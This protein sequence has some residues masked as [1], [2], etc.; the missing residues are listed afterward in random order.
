MSYLY[1][2]NFGYGELG[3]ALGTGIYTMTM[4]VGHNFP[5]DPSKLF[6][7]LIWD[8]TTYPEPADDP[9]KEIVTAYYS[10]TANVYVITRGDEGTTESSH[11]S[12]DACAM[13]ITAALMT[14]LENSGFPDY[15][16]G[17]ILL[18]SSDAP[19]TLINNPTVLTKAK[20]IKVVRAGTL[21]IKFRLTKTSSDPS[22]FIQG[23]IYRNGVAV[24]TL[25]SLGGINLPNTEEYSEDI[26]G[27]SIGDECQ[28]YIR[29]VSSIGLTSSCSNFRLYAAIPNVETVVYD[30]DPV[31]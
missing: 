19:R 27:W 23:K 10:G 31:A 25:R 20:S 17:D 9:A 5:T 3:S 30:A 28:L 6:K 26:S 1:K 21:R 16:A 29:R 12:G 14:E 22:S 2:Q 18:G 13:T 24:G 8:K 11:A 4:A 15:E 7:V